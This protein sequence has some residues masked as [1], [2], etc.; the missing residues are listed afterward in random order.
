MAKSESVGQF[1]Q[2]VLAAILSLRENAYGVTIHEKVAELAQP[3][4]VSLGAVYVT[5]DRLGGQRVP[6]FAAVRS[7]ARA[8]RPRQALL[9]T[10]SSRGARIAGFGSHGETHLGRHRKDLGQRMGQE[11][12]ERVEERGGIVQ[13]APP[14]ITEA[15]VGFLIPPASREHVTGDLHERYISTRQYIAD[16]MRTVPVVI[17]CRI[18]R[19]TDPQLLLVE[20]IA[21]YMSFLFAARQLNGMSFLYRD[22]GFERLAIPVVT[23]L[24]ALVLEDAYAR[25]SKPSAWRTLLD[26]ALAIGFGFLSQLLLFVWNRD[27]LVPNWI[28]ISAGSTSLLVLSILRTLF[29]PDSRRPTPPIR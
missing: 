5:L 25:P 18:R 20:A 10:G 24:A 28:M 14:K 26:V 4:A 1:E 17:V 6:L 2:L 19:T 21:L 12:G 15:V 9:P 3:K 27:L 23:M 22:G 11:V 29:P 7:H 8:W 16:A 13:P